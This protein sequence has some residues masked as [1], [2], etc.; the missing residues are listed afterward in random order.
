M[1]HEQSDLMTLD[2]VAQYM[3]TPI[4]TVRY[5]RATKQ[6]PRFARIGRRVMARR[7]DVEAFVDRQFEESA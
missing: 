5:W 3:H 6:G 7:I 1:D 4:S 2:E